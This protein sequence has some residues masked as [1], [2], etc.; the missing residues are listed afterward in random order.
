MTQEIKG[1]ARQR[2]SNLLEPNFIEFS[3]DK[4]NM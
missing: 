1:W 4:V 3:V 2:E